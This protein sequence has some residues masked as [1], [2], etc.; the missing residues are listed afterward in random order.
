CTRGSHTGW[1]DYIR[2]W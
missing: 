2:Y 1:T